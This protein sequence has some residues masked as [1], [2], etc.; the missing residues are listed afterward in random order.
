M[1]GS[2]DSTMILALL[3]ELFLLVLA[4]LV[5]AF[6]LIWSEERKR[7][8]GWLTAGGLAM[9]LV[10]SLLIARPGDE[11]I[12]VWGEMLRFDWLGFA[13]KI[14]FI[15]GAAITALFAMD[16]DELSKRGEFYILML[17]STLGMCLMVASSDLIMLYLAIE[18]TSIPLY[19]LAGFCLAFSE[20]CCG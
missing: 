5:L 19:I 7:D 4:G 12:F 18:T 20:V 10:I 16:V 3:P 14:I 8:L 15:F 11:P 1:S 17:V 6:D 2:I 9:T 13:F